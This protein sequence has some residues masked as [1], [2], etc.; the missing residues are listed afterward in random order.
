MCVCLCAYVRVDEYMLGKERTHLKGTHTEATQQEVTRRYSSQKYTQH[1][2][3]EASHPIAYER[4]NTTHQYC[5]LSAVCVTEFTLSIHH[6][7]YVTHH[8]SYIIHHTSYIIHHTSYIIHHTS[9]IIH[10]TS[11]TIQSLSQCS[12]VSAVC[13]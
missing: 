2:V 5:S 7:S 6:A 12:V 8:T 13:V 11:Y 10:H 9:Y 4:T 3:G 1:S